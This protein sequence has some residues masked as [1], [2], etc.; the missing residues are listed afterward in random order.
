MSARS[1]SGAITAS[2]W[3]RFTVSPSVDQ[4]LAD[5]AADLRADDDVVGRDDAGED[6]RGGAAFT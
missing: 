6:E 5:L 3:S 1:S 2:S 4:Q